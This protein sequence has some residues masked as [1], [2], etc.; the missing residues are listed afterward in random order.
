MTAAI[1]VTIV[2][3]GLTILVLALYLLKIALML[4]RA[5]SGLRTVNRNLKSIPPKAEP[6]APILDALSSDLGN[7]RALLEDL[8]RRKPQAPARPSAGPVRPPGPGTVA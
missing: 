3:A 8:L 6:V 1:V 7:A 4:R 2:V 5:L